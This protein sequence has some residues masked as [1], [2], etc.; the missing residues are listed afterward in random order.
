MTRPPPLSA[1]ADERLVLGALSGSLAR[2][3]APG[4]RLA[5]WRVFPLRPD[6]WAVR[7]ILEEPRSGRRRAIYA[8]T[9]A[10]GADLP[11]VEVG[12][13]TA[14][15]FRPSTD[16]RFETL[17]PLLD[18]EVAPEGTERARRVDLLSYRPHVRATCAVETADGSLVFARASAERRRFERV[19]AAQR[20]ASRLEGPDGPLFARAVAEDERRGIVFVEAIAGPT[21][22]ERLSEGRPPTPSAIRAVAR[23]LATLAESDPAPLPRQDPV[24]E[25][26]VAAWFVTRA[27]EVHPGAGEAERLL[28]AL[29]DRACALEE[30]VAAV[31]HR[32]LHDKQ[33]VLSGAAVRLLDP[34]TLSAADPLFDL[35]N[36]LVHLELRV[37]QGRVPKATAHGLRSALLEELERLGATPDPRRLAFH[38]ACTWLRLSGVYALRS[39]SRASLLPRLTE[40]ARRALESGRRSRL[41]SFLEESP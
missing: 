25:A 6:G 16:P 17:G 28:P 23:T 3:V 40:R 29:F 38:A 36:L 5:G 18:G 2:G 9:L 14:G 24:D 12:G 21:L 15:L 7:W 41:P 34:D 11:Q 31:C 13:V 4:S 10:A 32:D 20:F 30:G 26:E 1:L 39:S 19:L 35:A 8:S 27:R 33:V 37:L 22:C